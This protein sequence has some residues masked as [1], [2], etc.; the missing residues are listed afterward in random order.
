MSKVII[1]GDKITINGLIPIGEV[2]S[3]QVGVID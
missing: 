3:N 1:D 2:A